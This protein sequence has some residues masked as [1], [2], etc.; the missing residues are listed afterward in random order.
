MLP[1]ILTALVTFAVNEAFISR[2]VDRLPNSTLD[3]PLHH[4]SLHGQ[5][6]LYERVMLGDYTTCLTVPALAT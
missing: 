1:L 4:A 3:T 6:P 5:Q 2:G